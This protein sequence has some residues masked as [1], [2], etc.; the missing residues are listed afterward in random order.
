[1]NG[2]LYAQ[3]SQFG[4][5]ENEVVV[6]T[7]NLED[8]GSYRV[9]L[10]HTALGKEEK[11][12][13][14]IEIDFDACQ[15]SYM[16]VT[17]KIEVKIQKP[18]E[19]IALG[20]SHFLWDYLRR[21]GARGFFLPLSGGLDSASTM[22]LLYSMSRNVFEAVKGG[23]QK[24]L[25]DLR[26]IV[27]L[28]SFMPETPQ[29]IMNQISVT[30]YM[31]TSNSSSETKNRAENLSNA[32]GA[33]HFSVNIDE[34]VQATQNVFKQ[35]HEAPLKYKSEHGKWQEDLALQNIQARQR[36]VLSYLI[37]ALAPWMRGQDGF[38]LVLGSGNLD[39]TL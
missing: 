11:T 25:D 7:L 39:E 12:F 22:T 23:N 15:A 14:R 27:H 13:P 16:D 8:V 38:M 1:M 17:P 19:E 37:S 4:I 21:S 28:E 10:C 5:L 20:P 32:V 18:E 33:V 9:D 26:R 35:I 29:E 24:V 30:C 3:A 36:M 31:G 34:M 6:S 2:D